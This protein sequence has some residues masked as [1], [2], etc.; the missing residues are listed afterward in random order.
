MMF[1]IIT[2]MESVFNGFDPSGHFRIWGME[3]KFDSSSYGLLAKAVYSQSNIKDQKKE[4]LKLINGVTKINTYG[5]N[6]LFEAADC[7][8]EIIA[9]FICEEKIV[10]VNAM[11]CGVTPFW[12]AAQKGAIRT[13]KILKYYGADPKIISEKKTSALWIAAQNG[14][15]EIVKTLIRFGLDVNEPTY[16]GDSPLITALKHHDIFL[17]IEALCEKGAKDSSGSAL[18]YA[19]EKCTPQVI[20]Y[21]LTK[22]DYS[23]ELKRRLASATK[24][25]AKIQLLC[26]ELF[27]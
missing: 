17:C 20:Q 21:I 27:N 5:E 11:S 14:H 18:C 25:T 3:N 1:L 13:M 22:F 7:G 4:F 15:T 24:D 10:D 8:H 23:P 26:P 19:V 2:A 6:I 16:N 12:I 9:R